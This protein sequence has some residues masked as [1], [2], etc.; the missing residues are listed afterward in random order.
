V[1][2]LAKF[3]A[4]FIMDQHDEN[5][6][7]ETKPSLVKKTH[8]SNP[9]K[10]AL[11]EPLPSFGNILDVLHPRICTY[12]LRVDATFPYSTTTYVQLCMCIHIFQYTY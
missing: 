5:G 10:S 7:H 8:S 12:V 4:I 2:S 1:R 3:G 11:N 9:L 6:V